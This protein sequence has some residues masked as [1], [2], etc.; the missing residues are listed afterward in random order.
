[1]EG[2]YLNLE[3]KAIYN[4]PTANMMFY[5]KR[6]KAFLLRPGTRQGMPTLSPPTQLKILARA[7]R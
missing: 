4:R 3:K 7:I 2:M 1:M 5:R 6:W